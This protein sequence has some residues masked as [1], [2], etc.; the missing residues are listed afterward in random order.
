MDVWRVLDLETN[1]CATNM[2]IDEAILFHI[3][4]GQSPNT[5]RTYRWNPSAVSIGY[6]QSIYEEVD[7]EACQHL[8]VDVVRRIT[9][10]GAVYHDYEGEI[11]YSVLVREN[12]PKIPKDIIESYE[13]IC[14]GIIYALKDIGI[15]VNFKPINDIIAGTKKISGNAQTRRKPGKDVVVLQHGTILRD[16]DV[17]KMFSVLRVSKEKIKDKLI[18]QVEQRVTSIRRELGDQL[19]DFETLK[20]A[21]ERG[22]SKELSVQLERGT[23]TESERELAVK[24][25]EEKYGAKDWVF[26]R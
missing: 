2:A 6:F 10:G 8:G 18:E 12:D 14:Q 3:S 24:F 16:L 25:K 11:T 9:G 20:N 4:E 17:K 5:I 21:L 13:L 7:I 1:D 22:F 19:V 23:L 26:K 15:D